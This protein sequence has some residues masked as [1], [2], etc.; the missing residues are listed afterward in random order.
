MLA[1]VMSL[2]YPTSGQAYYYEDNPIS[3]NI[4]STPSTT[5]A[6]TILTR[7]YATEHNQIVS[8][9][10]ASSEEIIRSI[11]AGDITDLVLM[12]DTEGF[13]SLEQQGVLD[14]S[15][16]TPLFDSHFVLASA[17]NSRLAGRFPTGVP[18]EEALP[19]VQWLILPDPTTTHDGK[20]IQTALKGS[21]VWE[22]LSPFI[23]RTEHAR[24]AL[25]LIN[26]GQKAGIIS[27]ADA[28]SE[29]K[30]THIISHIPQK[31][32][33]PVQFQMAVVAGNNMERARHFLNY[34]STQTEEG[35][36]TQHGFSAMKKTPSKK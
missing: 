26:K 12:E 36:F 22:R 33:Q 8:V 6:L 21:G 17:E 31:L 18:F 20:S 16:I 23:E 14:V 25:Y 32:H 28:L 15:S 7:Q 24:K 29:P 5:Q 30:E 19:H 34:L 10:F 11:E 2:A 9:T 35:F 3:I 27:Y 4:L 13:K 1:L